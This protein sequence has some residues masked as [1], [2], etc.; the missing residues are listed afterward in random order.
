MVNAYFKN[1]RRQIL[2]ELDNS[3]KEIVVAVYWFTND[4]LFDK[5]LE[6]L[7]EGITVSLIIHNDFINN[8]AQGLPFQ[9]FIDAGGSFYFSDSQHPMH[10]KFCVIDGEVLINGSYNWT[11]FAEKKN[12]E[13][14]LIIKQHKELIKAFSEEFEN[15]RSGLVKV[16]EIASITEFEITDYNISD[17]KEYLAQDLLL[18]AKETGELESV[19]V[20]LK[21]VPLNTEIQKAAVDLQLI[22]KRKLKQAIGVSLTDNGYL[23]VIPKG[24]YIPTS[25]TQ[26]VQTVKD[27]QTSSYSSIHYGEENYATRNIKLFEFTLQGIPSKPAGEAK[28]KYRFSI[29]VKGLMAVEKF[30]LDNGN[31]VS[32]GCDINNLLEESEE[33]MV[34]D[35]KSKE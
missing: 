27:N 31:E 7:D 26:I 25:K 4:Q 1:I 28:M 3:T 19:D 8:R 9:K 17:T 33:V 30:S 13:N 15:L 23:I 14:V 5:L 35:T 11:Y 22:K 32:R 6:K 10:N 18:R 21:L 24:T 34:E 20:A 16:E 29:N 12:R 2:S